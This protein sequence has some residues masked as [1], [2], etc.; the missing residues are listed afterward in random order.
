[1]GRVIQEKRHAPM[2][3]LGLCGFPHGQ[4]LRPEEWRPQTIPHVA[5]VLRVHRW[6][7]TMWILSVQWPYFPLCGQ[8]GGISIHSNWNCLQCLP[9]LLFSETPFQGVWTEVS[10]LLHLFIV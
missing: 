1:M 10:I 4:S 9:S 2:D 6:E 5:Q 3:S 8:L 7:G